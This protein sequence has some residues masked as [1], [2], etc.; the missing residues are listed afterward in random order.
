MGIGF[1]SKVAEVEEE[2][3]PLYRTIIECPKCGRKDLMNLYKGYCNPEC[4]NLY[5]DV[6][7]T[8]S[9]CRFKA[10]FTHFKTVHYDEVEPVIYD[11]LIEQEL[12]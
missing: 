8:I 4:K 1:T 6:L 11:V 3:Q 7:P 5:I 2:R 10:T 9:E 12:P